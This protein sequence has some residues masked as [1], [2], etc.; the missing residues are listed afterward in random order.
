M[1]QGHRIPEARFAMPF[2]PSTSNCVPINH[3]DEAQRLAKLTAHLPGM[4]CQFRLFPDGTCCFPYVSAG[5]RNI[6]RLEPQDVQNDGT[7]VFDRVH[8]DDLAKVNASVR[9]SAVNLTLWHE[10]YR[11]KFD[12]DEVTW[13]EGRAQPERLEDGSILW[14]GFISDITRQKQNEQAIAHRESLFRK[15]ADASPVFIWM[16]SADG[17]MEYLNKTLLN[18]IGHDLQAMVGTG[19]RQAVHP[20]DAGPAYEHLMACMKARLPYEFQ[21]RYR[22][23][24]GVYRLTAN[25]ARPWFHDDGSL[26]G[27]I[28]SSIDI[29]EQKQAQDDVV[30]MRDQLDSILTSLPEV[31]Y[32]LSPDLSKNYFVGSATQAVY[33]RPSKDFLEDP[34]LWLKVI[35]PDDVSKIEEG[36]EELNRTDKS[37]T[38]YRVIRPDGSLGWVID[39]A[40]I[41]RD[42]SGT[43]VR[44]DGV[45]AD[46]T[47]R[48]KSDNDLRSARDAAQAA[49]R[50]KSEFLASMS[51]EIRTPMTAIVGYAHLLTSGRPTLQEQALWSG[52]IRSNSDYLLNLVND[53]LDLSKIEAGQIQL[54]TQPVDPWAIVQSVVNLMAP[55]ASEKMLSL[56]VSRF[57]DTPALTTTDG[58]RLRQILVNLV[59]NAIKFTDKGSIGLEMSCENDPQTNRTN[60][61]FVVSDTGIGID[62]EKFTQLFK[63]F[64]RISDGSPATLRPGTGLG[65]VIAMKFARMLG[66]A[67]TVESVPDQGSRFTVKIDAGQTSAL[68]FIPESDQSTLTPQAPHAPLAQNALLGAHILVTD[69]NP[70][71]QRIIKF[72]LEQSGA[73][74]EL[75]NHGGEAVDRIINPAGRPTIDV[76]LM[77][78]QMPV[79]DGYAATRILRS[80][81]HTF[82]IIALTA[83]TMS[84]DRQKCL[85]AG[86]NSYLT[87]P[88][89]PDT[90]IQE[91]VKWLPAK[92]ASR[93]EP[94]APSSTPARPPFAAS[95]R[96][97]ELVKEYLEGLTET[98]HKI[99]VHLLD[100]DFESLRVLVHKLK[101]SGSSYGF[102]LITKTASICE[103]A[104]KSGRTPEEITIAGRAV[105]E[106]I[107]AA[108]IKRG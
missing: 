36:L 42:K 78:M 106:Q 49:S 30:K 67:I 27:Y 107:D 68:N 71:N 10:Q 85:D 97:A 50:H 17:Q 54:Q 45:V 80:K 32:S 21:L 28:G 90:L 39:T 33:G 1:P 95:G 23:N 51:H 57:G 55:R 19:W 14:H 56:E 13:V 89:I 93:Q 105:V 47:H 35:H 37:C 102:P 99:L 43:P 76:A 40:R 34:N 100:T 31:V 22:R 5:I 11:L 63:P 18:F 82:P 24:D 92:A 41:I 2:T 61:V 77:D 8:P 88:I 46:I 91:V 108:L 12:D 16:M 62:P 96:F 44:I 83:Y 58:T 20:S 65:L 4:V 7:R 75:A 25:W 15:I 6:Y 74:V 73:T 86:C 72:I 52:H 103:T 70:D 69:D 26:G 87:K 48:V 9:T 101:G 94:S 104:I 66:G 64:S 81:N 3:I 84:G 38:E 29:T 98:R 59:S 60:L 53:I 79:C